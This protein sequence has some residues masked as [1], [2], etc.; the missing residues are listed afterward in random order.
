MFKS[1]LLTAVD[2]KLA[3]ISGPSI[4][5]FT[6]SPA[7]DIAEEPVYNAD[8]AWPDEARII[9]A[10]DLGA[11]NREIF[12][13]YADRQPQRRVYRFDESDYSLQYIGTAGELAYNR[14]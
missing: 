2:A 11:R 5:L 3:G 12:R 6:Y 13:Y 14:N 4:V 7:R 10:H 9:R 1:P 8:V